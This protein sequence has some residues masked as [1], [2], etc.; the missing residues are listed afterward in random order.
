MVQPFTMPKFGQTMEEGT[1]VRWLKNEGAII[2]KGDIV[3]EVETDKAVLEVESDM[4]GVL[5]KI[6]AKEEQVL[7][8]GETLAW[9]GQPGEKFRYKATL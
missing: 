8:C 9:I 2:K 5:L 6:V 3:L 4:D 7:K 1:V